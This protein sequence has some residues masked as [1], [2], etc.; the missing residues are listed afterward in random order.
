MHTIRRLKD[1][2]YCLAQAKALGAQVEK[3]GNGPEKA[4]LMRVFYSYTLL[5]KLAATKKS[6][7]SN[8]ISESTDP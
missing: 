5:A 6:T 4:S 2:H 3:I 7:S 1:P 8:E